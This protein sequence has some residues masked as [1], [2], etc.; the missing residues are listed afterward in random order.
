LLRLAGAGLCKER[1]EK[2]NAGGLP[3]FGPQR[4]VIPYSYF[5]VYLSVLEFL[6]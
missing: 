5:G 2:M 3:R 4:C 1:A 6:N